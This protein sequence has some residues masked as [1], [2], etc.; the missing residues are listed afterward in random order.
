[1]YDDDLIKSETT[2]LFDEKPNLE[3]KL[4]KLRS[5]IVCIRNTIKHSEDVHVS[6]GVFD[7]FNSLANSSVREYRSLETL[8]GVK[9][10]F[11]PTFEESKMASE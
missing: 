7:S 5:V 8:K 2:V 1:M 4:N 11:E 9:S 10:N 3:A 6:F